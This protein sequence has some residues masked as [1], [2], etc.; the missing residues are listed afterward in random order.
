MHVKERSS[1]TALKKVIPQATLIEADC[2]VGC[3]GG[4][5]ELEVYGAIV[6]KDDIA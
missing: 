1:C 5:P 2:D 3:S 4:F 6:H